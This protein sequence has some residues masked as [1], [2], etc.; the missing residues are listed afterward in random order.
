MD[1]LISH[2][3]EKV[4][5]KVMCDWREG[6]DANGGCM[7]PMDAA[8]FQWMLHDT[9]T[10]FDGKGNLRQKSQSND[11]RALKERCIARLTA[12]LIP[13]LDSTKDSSVAWASSC[14]VMHRLVL[15]GEESIP[16]VIIVIAIIISAVLFARRR[17]WCFCCLHVC[18]SISFLT[19][20][21]YFSSLVFFSRGKRCTQQSNW[22]REDFLYWMM[23]CLLSQNVRSCLW[24]PSSSSCSF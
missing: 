3:K 14:P 6:D 12:S 17:W 11:E 4:V 20:I 7:I 23:S 9:A 15:K 1:A 18:Y 21:S 2:E 24:C 19:I 13:Y 8:W 10:V 16:V 22:I 5:L